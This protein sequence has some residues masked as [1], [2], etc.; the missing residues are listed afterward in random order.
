[1]FTYLS[2]RIDR[3]RSAFIH[4]PT[5]EH[6]SALQMAQ[7]LKVAVSAMLRQVNESDNKQMWFCTF[8]LSCSS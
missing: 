2:L 5:A 4:V 7:M 8:Q 6:Y 1:M 3:K